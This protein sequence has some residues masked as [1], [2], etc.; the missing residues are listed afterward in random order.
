MYSF[1]ILFSVEENYFFSICDKRI[2]LLKAIPVQVGAPEKKLTF[3]T[4]PRKLATAKSMEQS[5]WPESLK[6]A[7][8]HTGT[9]LSMCVEL[10][11][12]D[13]ATL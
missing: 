3:Y 4:T 5:S 1:S 6:S 7:L 13:G 10:A 2:N 12:R 9:H 11:G 8:D